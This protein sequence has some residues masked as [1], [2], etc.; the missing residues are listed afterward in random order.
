M[1][2]IE[3]KGA[4]AVTFTTK[5]TKVV[6][7]PGLATVGAKDVATDGSIVV[8]TEDRFA[9]KAGKPTLVFEGPGE[10]EAGEVA[11]KGVAA[12]RHIDNEEQGW[13]STA[14]RMVIG[15]IRVAVIGNI[16]PR[17]D[18]DQLEALGVIDILVLPVGGG[19]LTLDAT[20]AATVARQIEPRFIIPVHYAESALK[21]EV[22]QEDMDLFVKEM[23]VG[24]IE[25]GL[26]HKI[27]GDSGLPDQMTVLKI[28]RS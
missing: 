26:K 24:V 6:F 21:Y 16:A 8:L 7:D 1:F 19:G 18:D 2:D 13:G 14:Y 4:N 12:R 23:G 11:L 5:K 10:Y 28:T 20:D 9:A 27:K 25:A 17:L 15:D 3:Y 22:P